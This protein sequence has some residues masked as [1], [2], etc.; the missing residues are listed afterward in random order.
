MAESKGFWRVGLSTC[1]KTIDEKLFEAY[2]TCGITDM[3]ISTASELYASLDYKKM[4]T[5]A[6][7]YDVNLWSYHLPFAPFSEIDISEQD[8]RKQTIEYISELIKKAADIGVGVFVIHSSG[9]PIE[10]EDRK[11][12]LECAKE[13]LAELAEIAGR[14]GAVIAVEDLP[15]TCLGRDSGDILELISA[16]P[17]LR[18]CFDTNHLLKED[19]SGFIR[20]AGDKIIT[21]HV[22]DYD[23]INERHWMPGEGDI[24]WQSVLAALREVGYN[25]PWLY[26]I[27]LETPGTIERRKL[28]IADFEDNARALFEGVTPTAIGKRKPNLGMWG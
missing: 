4:Y 24:E 2:Q 27:G 3:E 18:V 7:K 5:W 15:R 14:S 16:H 9:E 11:K 17:A 12:R 10:E 21:T 19:I 13:S 26:E 6:Q 20:K 23:F 8:L 1:G 25:G 22:S 28:E